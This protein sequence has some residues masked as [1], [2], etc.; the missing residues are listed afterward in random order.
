MCGKPAE[1][2]VFFQPVG[3]RDLHRAVERQLAVVNA[4]Q[5]FVG[6]LNYVVAFQQLGAEPARV[7]SIFLAR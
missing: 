3:D 6:L 1:N 5:H 7:S 4:L 2:L